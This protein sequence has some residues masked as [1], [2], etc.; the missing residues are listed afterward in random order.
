MFT[1]EQKAARH[2]LAHLLEQI[3][4]SEHD[5]LVEAAIDVSDAIEQSTRG[6]FQTGAAF[7]LVKRYASLLSTVYG[8][9]AEQNIPY[10]PMEL[11]REHYT[12]Q[13]YGWATREIAAKRAE[14][15]YSGRGYDLE[16]TDAGRWVVVPR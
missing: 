14:Q 11:D 13:L 8:F 3:A 5:E 2:I 12:D 1:N 7:D 6:I 4:M 15:F 10:G 16:Q 9:E